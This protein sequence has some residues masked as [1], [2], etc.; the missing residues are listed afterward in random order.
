MDNL[1]L[2]GEKTIKADFIFLVR[3]ALTDLGQPTTSLDNIYDVF[4][5]TANLLTQF[6]AN[7]EN[8]ATAKTIAEYVTTR[9]S[10]YRRTDVQIRMDEV[11][12]LL[13]FLSQYR[14]LTNHTFQGLI[15]DTLSYLQSGTRTD[16]STKITAIGDQ[17]SQL[18]LDLAR[19]SI[20]QTGE[21]VVQTDES[22]TSYIA[23]H[24]RDKL[25]DLVWQAGKKPPKLFGRQ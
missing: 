3:Q 10:D 22:Y 23:T 14:L 8:P 25:T 20:A 1:T 9:L 6:D 5:Q 4:L 11:E 13:T 12:N 17:I 15:C 2:S 21:N 16:L 7:S 24:A 19:F 18:Q